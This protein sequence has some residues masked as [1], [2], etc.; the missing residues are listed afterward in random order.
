MILDKKPPMASLD[1]QDTLGMVWQLRVAISFASLQFC[2]SECT[3]AAWLLFPD[4]PIHT[5]HGEP[6]PALCLVHVYPLWSQTEG[7]GVCRFVALL[8]L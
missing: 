6:F 3:A 8:Y 2:G 5:V 4:F 7:N 1:G